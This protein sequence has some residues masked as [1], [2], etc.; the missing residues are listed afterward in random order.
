[1]TEPRRSKL[2]LAIKIYLDVAWW[3]C[4]AAVVPLA[5]ILPILAFAQIEEPVE[6]SVLARF[7]IEGAADG[8]DPGASPAAT[9]DVRGQG[10][11]RIPSRDKTAWASQIIGILA[12]L[13]VLLY[14]LRHLRGV[15]KTVRAGQPFDRRNAGRIRNVGLVVVGWNLL[16]PFAKYWVGKLVLAGVRLPGVE[17]LPPIDFRPDALFL[18]LAIL[19]LAEIF[20]RA[21]RLQ[22]EQDLTV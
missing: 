12:V 11:L 21:S 9:G 6:M 16:T 15:L 4:L 1:M 8:A 13:A 10:M 17:L 22:Q 5:V 3:A 18:G 2:A 7:H 14:V 19:V 20:H